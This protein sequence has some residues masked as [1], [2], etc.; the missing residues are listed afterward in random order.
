MVIGVFMFV[1][2]VFSLSLH[3]PLKP[4]HVLSG[5]THSQYLNLNLCAC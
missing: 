5:F 4:L 1:N 2:W 3:T